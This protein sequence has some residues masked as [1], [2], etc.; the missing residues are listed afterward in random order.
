VSSIEPI[1]PEQARAILDQ[2]MAERLGQNW[3]DE[4]SGW[5]L[6]SGHDYMA[7][8]TRSHKNVDFYVDLLGSVT[9]EEKEISPAQSNGRLVAWALL[10]V[11]LGLAYLLARVVGWF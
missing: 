10:L 11:S 2:A 9:I 7:R 5:I 3:Q 4:D 8:V 6:V 1:A